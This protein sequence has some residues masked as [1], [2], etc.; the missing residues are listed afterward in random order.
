MTVH[1]EY[2]MTVTKTAVCAHPDDHGG[3]PKYCHYLCGHYRD[4]A[5]AKIV[6]YPPSDSTTCNHFKKSLQRAPD[7]STDDHPYYFR[8]EECMQSAVARLDYQ[9]EDEAEWLHEDVRKFV[10]GL[11]FVKGPDRE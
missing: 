4:R 2:I 9:E 8:C 7:L 11:S 5:R 6:T 1:I 10:E 3:E